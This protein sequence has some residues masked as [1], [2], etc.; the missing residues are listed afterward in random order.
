VSELLRVVKHIV[1]VEVSK[2]VTYQLGLVLGRRH[3]TF[4][5]MCN[6]S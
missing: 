1:E 6:V 5:F 2:T 4:C 3:A